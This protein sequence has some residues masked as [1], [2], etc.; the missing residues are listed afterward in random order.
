[1][2]FDRTRR[3]RGQILVLTT[4]SLIAL[5]GIL[6]LAVDI[7]WSYYLR[8][9]AQR[10]ADA[11]SMAAAIQILANVG[12]NT[13]TCGSNVT[14]QNSTVCPSNIT[15]PTTN[16]MEVACLYAQQNGFI[17]GGNN[18]KQNVTV[19]SG[20]TMPPP[21]AP[22]VNGLYYWVTVRVTQSSPIWFGNVV[23]DATSA[24][25]VG[26]VQSAVT[27]LQ[28]LPIAFALL[29]GIGPA[30]RASAG[31]SDGILG[32]TLFLLNRQNDTS[33]AGSLGEDLSNGGNP[34]ITAP[35]GIY[36]SSTLNGANGVYAG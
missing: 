5:F 28:R 10:A 31:V 17:A 30:A 21:T 6:A 2:R 4:L 7:G 15:T 20:T 8:K 11:A 18:G 9:W 16:E 22:G 36:M 35:G 14:C 27:P 29:G 3:Q 12:N 26:N 13:V 24:R 23:A 25:G 1:M 19:A 34:T 33:G 32:G